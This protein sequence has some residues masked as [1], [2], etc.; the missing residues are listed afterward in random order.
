MMIIIVMMKYL[1]PQKLVK[2]I[3]SRDLIQKK[4]NNFSMNLFCQIRVA[5]VHILQV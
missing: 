5:M 2:K 4:R 1:Q 3:Y